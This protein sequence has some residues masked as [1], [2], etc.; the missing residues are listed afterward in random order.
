MSKM[1]GKAPI[2]CSDNNTLLTKWQAIIEKAKKIDV[3]A[4]L[5][6]GEKAT[7]EEIALLEKELKILLPPSYRNAMLNIGKSFSLFYSLTGYVLP[8]EFCDISFGDL[9]WDIEDFGKML[10]WDIDEDE[11]SDVVQRMK[12]LYRFSASGCGDIYAF[13]MSA[14][15]LEKPVVYWNHET[16]EISYIADSFK[17]YLEKITDLYCIGNDI[18]AFKNFLD[19]KGLNTDTE[20]ARRWKKWFELLTSIELAD[21]R[22]NF[23]E[24]FEFAICQKNIDELTIEALKSY[25]KELLFERLKEA[26]KENPERQEV[27][28]KMI[29]LILGEDAGDWLMDFWNNATESKEQY[30]DDLEFNRI[31]ISSQLL[32][33]LTANCLDEGT[34]V[35]YVIELLEKRYGDNPEIDIPAY[36]H[37]RYF[38]AS[39]VIP[40]IERR[41]IHRPAWWGQL[42]VE[43]QPEWENYLR[44]LKLDEPFQSALVEGLHHLIRNP[45]YKIPN[46]PPKED[47]RFFLE[48]LKEGQILSI[49]KKMVDEVIE[50]FY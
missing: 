39:Q 48:E 28:C 47:F 46:L 34:G 2:S 11:E 43:V 20:K 40:W 27:A 41:A 21:V 24:L 29:A 49:R 50:K 5:E 44:W 26:L 12:M 9:H 35:K 25:R 7:L 6:I 3:E 14:D 10:T 1:I 38:K 8:D 31:R 36:H 23:D 45:E 32:A 17:E 4:D 19:D 16:W 13:D 37:L 30:S 22:D 42:F 15:T 33:Y 18:W